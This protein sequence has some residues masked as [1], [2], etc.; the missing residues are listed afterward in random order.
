MG[1]GGGH[2][3]V[4]IRKIRNEDMTNVMEVTS[5]LIRIKQRWISIDSYLT[6]D[7]SLSLLSMHFRQ[8][9]CAIPLSNSEGFISTETNIFRALAENLTLYT[10]PPRLTS[11]AVL[12]P[13]THRASSSPA[14]RTPRCTSWTRRR[15]RPRSDPVPR[16]RD[17]AC[18]WRT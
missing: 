3:F 11:N 13:F 12:L 18:W 8:D 10:S 17:P 2:L 16:G 1:G 7:P 15:T 9:T 5:N 4:N 6:F 14:C